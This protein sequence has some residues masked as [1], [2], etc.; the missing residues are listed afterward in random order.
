MAILVGFYYLVYKGMAAQKES[1]IQTRDAL[2]GEL[3]EK[4]ILAANLERL[5]LEI[6]ALESQLSDALLVL[7]E[8]KEIPTLLVNINSLGLKS[9]IE[10]LLFRPGGLIMRDF[11]GEFPVQMK[12]QGT[13]HGLGRFFDM[14]SK[15]PRIVNVSE[16]K[17]SP[18]APGEESEDT[19]IAEFAA[20]TFTF[21]GTRGGKG[22]GSASGK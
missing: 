15:M 11:Y 10:F 12:V 22:S 14:I 18:L 6:A 4:R 16:L 19:I 8:E 3:R 1:L 7:P 13:Y 21:S 20:T 5:K 2:Q 17:I 9:G